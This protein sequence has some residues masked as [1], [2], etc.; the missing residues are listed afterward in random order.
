MI[1][2]LALFAF[3]AAAP[4]AAAADAPTRV[5]IPIEEQ[6]NAR[7]PTKIVLVASGPYFKP[8]EHE[9]LA[10]CGALRLLLAQT[11]GVFPVVVKEWPTSPDTFAGAK[12]VLFY[13]NG[14]ATN[15]LAKEHAAEVQKL[16]DAGVGL[17]ALHQMADYA[18]DFG[19]RA[20]GWFGGCYEPGFS[21]R[22]HWV[23]S[24]NKFPEHPITRGVTPFKIDDGYL[25]KLRFVDGMKGVTPL[26]RASDPKKD[27]KKLAA[28]PDADV[29]AWA[30]ERPGGGRS[31]VFTGRTPAREP[32]R[33]GL[34][35]LPDQRRAVGR[36][37]GGAAGGGEGRDRRGRAQGSACDAAGEEVRAQN[38]TPR[39]PP[40]SGEGE[41]EGTSNPRHSSTPLPA[42]GRGRGWGSEASR[43]TEPLSRRLTQLP[44]QGRQ[45]L[46]LV[47]GV[48]PARVRQHPDAASRR[49]PRPA[50]RA[51][52]SAGRRRCGTRRRRAPPGTRGAVLSHLL[53]QPLAAR[54]QLFGGQLV[55]R[56]GG[57]LDH[58]RDAVAEREQAR[59]PRAGEAAAG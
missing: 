53:P 41:E 58:V 1:R 59:A 24:Y 21:K 43:L 49:S 37:R 9:Y 28:G 52:P 42:S 8:G 36:R 13:G 29:V 12:A 30:Y 5:A 18:K 32:G 19:D 34:P 47:V 40:R 55:G 15:P 14:G 50:G 23:D 3:F 44:E 25:Y 6:P 2:R 17:V 56:G 57:A 20:R 46:G 54:D 27:P 51:P 4:L 26:L 35:P 45:S 33:G 7:F 38:P 10:G 16:A 39:P 22:A 11:P 48:E 31:F